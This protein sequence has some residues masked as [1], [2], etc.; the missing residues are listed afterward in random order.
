MEING[1]PLS[2]QERLLGEALSQ[3]IRSEVASDLA[4]NTTESYSPYADLAI[5]FEKKNMNLCNLKDKFRKLRNQVLEGKGRCTLRCLPLATILTIIWGFIS[6]R[7]RE[8]QN[9]YQIQNILDLIPS[10]KR[11]EFNKLFVDLVTQSGQKLCC[12]TIKQLLE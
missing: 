10:N 5:E 2:Y 8:N 11:I 1:V 6:V 7:Q 9:F 3:R 4:A 12:G